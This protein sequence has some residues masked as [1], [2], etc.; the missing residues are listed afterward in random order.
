MSSH[1][2]IANI[3]IITKGRFSNKKYT[4]SIP[5]NLEHNISINQLVNVYFNK[6][7][8]KGIITSIDKLQT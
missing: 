2:Y 6:R 1:N 7:Y 3:I 5:Q 4:Y 8:V